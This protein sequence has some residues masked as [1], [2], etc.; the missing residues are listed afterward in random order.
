MTTLTTKGES[1]TMIALTSMML[2][3]GSLAVPGAQAE[4][5]AAREKPRI[6]VTEIEAFEVTS[7]R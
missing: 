3:L 7:S 1:K 2:V 5:P 4:Q 6:T